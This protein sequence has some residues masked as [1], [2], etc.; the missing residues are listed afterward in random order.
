MGTLHRSTVP[1]LLFVS[2]CGADKG[3]STEA[4]CASAPAPVGTTVAGDANGDG[5]VDVSDGMYVARSVFSG[6]PTACAEASDLADDD[7]VDAAD[8]F[9]LW[10]WLGPGANTWLPTLEAGACPAPTRAAPAGCADGLALSVSA[11]E[12]VEGAGTVQFEA[13]VQLAHP[14][15]D[16]E[17]WSFGIEATGCTLSAASTNGTNAADLRD[18]PPGS[19]DGGM[20]WVHLRDAS[21]ALSLVVVD[22]RRDATLEASALPSAV[23]ALDVSA[24]V[25]DSCA[26]CTLTLVSGEEGPGAPVEA[27]VSAEG[28]RYVPELGSAVTSVCP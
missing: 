14:S 24:A 19:R 7:V 23:L 2:A 18:D 5:W 16:V 10:S 9:A 17:A 13:T 28:L 15:L 22:W 8:A 20:S 21:T 1:L 26:P 6:G 27:V 12:E 4:V 3:A 11:P 25:G